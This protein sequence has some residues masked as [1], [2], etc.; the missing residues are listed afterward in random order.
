MFGT[1][2]LEPG[3][4][5]GRLQADH[6]YSGCGGGHGVARR[7]ASSS[8]ACSCNPQRPYTPHP[9]PSTL[10]TLYIRHYSTVISKVGCNDIYPISYKSTVY[11]TGRGQRTSSLYGATV[12]VCLCVVVGVVSSVGPVCACVCPSVPSYLPSVTLPRWG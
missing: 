1:S 7:G 3:V 4:G 9:A 8:D 11:S 5:G 12:S 10:I 2:W 6:T